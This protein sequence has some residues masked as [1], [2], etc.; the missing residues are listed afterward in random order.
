MSDWG[1]ARK[2]VDDCLAEHGRSDAAARANRERGYK[3]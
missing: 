3:S 1:G 2:A